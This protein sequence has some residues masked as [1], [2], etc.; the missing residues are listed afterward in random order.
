VRLFNRKALIVTGE[1]SGETHALHLVNALSKFLPLQWSA[2]GSERLKAAGVDILYDYRAI[3]VTG[4][5]EVVPKMGHIWTAYRRLKRYLLETLPSLLILVDFPGFNLRVAAMAKNLGISVVYFIPPQVWAWRPAR[6]ERIKRDVELIISILPFEKALYDRHGIPSVYVGHPFMAAVQPTRPRNSFLEEM[7]L[8]GR[9]PIITVM[10]GSRENEVARHMPVLLQVVSRLRDQLD[11]MA[12]LLPV[13]ENIDRGTIETFTKDT[14]YIHL[15]EGMSH[16]A[17]ACSDVALVASGSATLEA[18]ILNCP[19]IVIYKVS[20]LS[21]LAAK[22]LVKVSH[23]SLP[24]LIAG[25]E[26][27]PEYIQH[28]DAETVAQRA[29]HMLNNEMV[30]VRKGMEEVRRKLGT[31]DSYGLARDA[32]IRFL[33]LTYGPL[34]PAS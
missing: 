12:V 30:D 23:V 2:I 21:F 29:L 17:L 25:K 8:T 1:L 11:N 26:V 33:E 32:I 16:D 5:S 34:F 28:L 9:A 10:P 4:L 15:L 3:S 13:A 24:N 19:A 14:Q 27:F 6:I 22:Y 7:G 31:S 18:A 20:T